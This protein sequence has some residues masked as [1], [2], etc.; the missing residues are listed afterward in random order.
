MTRDERIIYLYQQGLS[1]KNVGIRE[2]ITATGI[3]NILIKYNI[4]RRSR[5]GVVKLTKQ[6]IEESQKRYD[7]GE[8]STT[9]AKDLGVDPTTVRR[10]LT[11]MRPTGHHTKLPFNEHAF[12]FTHIDNL[13]EE[14]AYWIGFLM[15]D[16]SVFLDSG[17]YRVAITL[18]SKDKGHLEKFKNFL[19]ASNKISCGN[20][21]GYSD[22][23]TCNIIVS[24]DILAAD[25]AVFGIVPKKSKTAKVLYLQDNKHFWRGLLDA[26]GWVSLGNGIILTGSHSNTYL[27]CKYCNT[28]LGTNI[29]PY[30]SGTVWQAG[31]RSK[32]ANEI[33]EHFYKDA[34][35]YLDRKNPYVS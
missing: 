6:Q 7:L 3:R 9:I 14:Q 29:N 23:P 28:T 17:R 26:D 24:S 13:T 22:I 11:R 21:G 30:R 19:Q 12:S 1:L 8:P 27:F 18:S 4:P 34:T 20:Y 5:G 35:I 33:I 10:Y 16:G 31:T 15:G 25:L 32:S 2:G